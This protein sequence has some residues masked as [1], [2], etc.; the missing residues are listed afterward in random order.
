MSGGK[1]P[2]PII[3]AEAFAKPAWPSPLILDFTTA[4]IFAAFPQQSLLLKRTPYKHM[5]FSIFSPA[6]G[7]HLSPFNSQRLH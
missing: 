6:C 5:A 1:A 4:D 3:Y 7:L 2:V